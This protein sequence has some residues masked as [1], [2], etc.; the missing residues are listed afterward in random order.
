MQIIPDGTASLIY[1]HRTADNVITDSEVLDAMKWEYI[2]RIE[3][4]VS[5]KDPSIYSATS[6]DYLGGSTS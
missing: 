3:R 5:D 2:F 4:A 6:R 1:T